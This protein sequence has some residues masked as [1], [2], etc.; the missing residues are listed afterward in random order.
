MTASG[1][2]HFHASESLE[3][4]NYLSRH[5]LPRCITAVGNPNCLL[6]IWMSRSTLQYH[7]FHDC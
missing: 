5:A 1:K 4:C 2:I 6:Y 3:V 7:H